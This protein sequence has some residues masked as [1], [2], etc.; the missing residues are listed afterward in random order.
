MMKILAIMSFGFCLALSSS[1]S[2]E[3]SNKSDAWHYPFPPFDQ[4]DLAFDKHD[5][6]EL[7]KPSTPFLESVTPYYEKS[8]TELRSIM[9]FGA[10]T[11][12]HQ[13]ALILVR[14]GD[15]EAILRT[16]YGLKQGNPLAE[17]ILRTFPSRQVIPFLMEDVAH[18]S[19]ED[20][21]QDWP[22]LAYG[23]PRLVATEVVASILNNIDDFPEPVREWLKYV[24]HGN[25][26]IK[27]RNLSEKS[28]FLVEWWILNEK[29][30]IE[31]RWDDVVPVP[32]SGSYSTKLKP[33]LSPAGAGE[34]APPSEEETH[35]PWKFKPLDVPESFEDWSARIV[36]PERRDL[37]WV[38]LTF[39]KDKWVEYPAIR[40][41][42]LAPPSDPSRSV[43]RP[44]PSTEGVSEAPIRWPVWIASLVALFGLFLWWF[45][46]SKTAA[47]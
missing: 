2:G 35:E 34:F 22:N 1:G 6:A 32:H 21:G 42:P 45:S 14:A 38:K 13:A 33:D 24:R 9:S 25:T 11:E 40:L 5:S 3:D 39:E 29:A 43:R 16:V 19:M 46:S 15:R 37:R 8:V 7:L 36:H 31:E 28:K 18:G 17:E 30:F 47:P 27:I 20:F 4:A 41:D 12:Q 26:S 44:A 10:A 23:K